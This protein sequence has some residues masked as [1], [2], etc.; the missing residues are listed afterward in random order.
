MGM[1]LSCR[2]KMLG[3]ETGVAAKWQKRSAHLFY[4]ITD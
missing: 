4:E 1:S 2:L 3:P